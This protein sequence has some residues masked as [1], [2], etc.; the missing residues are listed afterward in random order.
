MRGF[1]AATPDGSSAHRSV[2][3]C[4]VG[5]QSSLGS[6]SAD[7]WI[8]RL[9]PAPVRN[10]RCYHFSASD[11]I[12]RF[13]ASSGVDPLART[14]KNPWQIPLIHATTPTVPRK[15]LFRRASHQME[16]PNGTSKWNVSECQSHAGQDVAS[17]TSS[18]DAR[19]GAKLRSMSASTAVWI[20][21]GSVVETESARAVIG[22]GQ[23]RW[24]SGWPCSG[25]R[26]P[27]RN[28][29]SARTWTGYSLDA[30]GPSPL[31]AE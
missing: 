18:V 15:T 8:V 2:V 24:R 20:F 17:P 31:E 12:P 7:S 23:D 26:C 25:R 5:C 9:A 10:R 1:P 6:R 13:A 22:G 19:G 3:E 11:N 29:G 14:P 21:F 4:T 30:F 28:R 16:H 27:E